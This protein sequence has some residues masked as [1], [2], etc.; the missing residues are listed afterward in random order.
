MLLSEYDYNLPE[1]LIA[2]M[3]CDKRENSKMLVLN[4]EKHLIEHKHFY[5]IVE[6]LGSNTLLVMN[7]TKVL[8][9][10]LIGYKDTGAKIEVFLLKSAETSEDSCIWDVLV[11]PSKRVK[12][13]MI[14]RMSDELSVKVL[15]RLEDNGE[16]LVELLYDKEKNLL[17]ILHFRLI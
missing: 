8:P 14:I 5:D 10:R 9:A 3:P 17:D 7:N 13:D 4:R 15:K 12:P 1:E 11:K 6:L 2:Q 16:W